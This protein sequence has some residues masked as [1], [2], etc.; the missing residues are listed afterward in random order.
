[1]LQ[2]VIFLIETVMR[3]TWA[4]GNDAGMANK[5]HYFKFKIFYV[6]I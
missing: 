6:C 1:M 2:D 3:A 4:F 5:N